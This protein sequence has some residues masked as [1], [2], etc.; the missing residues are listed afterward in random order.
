VAISPRNGLKTLCHQ[1]ANGLPKQ[2]VCATKPPCEGGCLLFGRHQAYGD[3]RLCLGGVEGDALPYISV[4][5]EGE[6]VG[7]GWH[8]PGEFAIGVGIT[9]DARQGDRAR[10]G[11]NG[12]DDDTR[13]RVANLVQDLP[14]YVGQCLRG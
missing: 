14:G 7:T 1:C 10:S 8:R 3:W 13:E 5:L 4:S 2:T 6:I 11:R 9:Y 12:G